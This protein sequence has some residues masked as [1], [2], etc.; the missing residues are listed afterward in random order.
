MCH[1]PQVAQT[2]DVALSFYAR[3]GYKT[4]SAFEKGMAGAGAI[5]IVRTGFWWDVQSRDKFVMRRPLYFG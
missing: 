5:E 1:G 2:N 4:V 3:N